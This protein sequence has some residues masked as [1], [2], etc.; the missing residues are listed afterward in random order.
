MGMKIPDHLLDKIRSIPDKPG[1]Y[2]MKDVQGNIIYIGKS[3]CLSKRVKSYFQTNHDWEKIKRLVFNIYDIDFIVT[4]THL[5][6]QLLE[7]K[8]IK[9]YKPL[10]NSQFSKDKNYV[11][12]KIEEHIT[13]NPLSLSSEK[14]GEYVFGPFK[15]RRVIYD[16]T[17]LMTKLYPIKKLENSYQIQYN[18]LPQIMDEKDFKENRMCLIEIFSKEK[19]METFLE[20]LEEKM[21]EASYSFLYERASYFRDMLSSLKYI[22]ESQKKDISK[23]KS[24]LM[25]E[26]IEKGYK[27]FY[28]YDGNLIIKRKFYTLTI[29]DIDE[30]IHQAE[31]SK[32]FYNINKDEKRNMDFKTI[33]NRELRDRTSKVIEIIDDNFHSG[34]FWSKLV[35]L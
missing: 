2:K 32:N 25:G 3:K 20:V 27:L 16:L 1:V 17:E 29:K 22:Y 30:F 15:S 14:D 23:D 9:K 26:K 33:I 10:Y 4:D 5:E 7:C 31:N 19:C 6:A 18:P 21:K 13:A 34:L 24:I 28:I 35:K 12:L 11:Y 8:L